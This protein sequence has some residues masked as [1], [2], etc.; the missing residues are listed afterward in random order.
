MPTEIHCWRKSRKDRRCGNSLIASLLRAFSLVV[1]PDQLE[2]P[3]PMTLS[4]YQA[5]VPVFVKSLTALS[6]V[7]DKAVA[8]ASARKIEPTVLTHMRLYPDMFPMFRQVRAATDHATGAAGRL[9]GVELPK[10]PDGESLD[11]LKLRVTKAVEFLNSLTAAQIEGSEEKEITL[12]LGQRSAS[13]KGQ[14]YLLQFAIP[15]FFFHYT[16]GYNIL[17]HAGVEIGKRDFMG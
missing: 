6:S 9:A 14:A 5:S 7:L 3:H 10:L 4:M 8:H 17:R 15:N 1:A 2:G 11:E 12:Q 16:T 13:F